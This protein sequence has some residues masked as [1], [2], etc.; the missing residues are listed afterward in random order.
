MRPISPRRRPREG[1]FTLI[2]VIIAVIILGIVALSLM[3]ASARMIGGVTD[4]RL[5]T[6]AAA[7]ADDRI[8]QVLAWPTYATLD[9]TFAGTQANTPQAGLSRTT[10]IVRTGGTGQ[11]NDFKRVTVEVNGAAL[12]APVRRTV[13]VAAP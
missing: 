3:S 10:T 4:D 13:T 5:R 1:G 9:A 11:T 12:A 8:A 6:L 7:S 2:E